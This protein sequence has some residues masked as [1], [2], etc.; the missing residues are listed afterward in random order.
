MTEQPFVFYQTFLKNIK[1]WRANM[2]KT[3]RNLHGCLSVNPDQSIS[4]YN[5][6]GGSAVFID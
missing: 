5:K 3:D 2:T 4:R 6:S 1:R